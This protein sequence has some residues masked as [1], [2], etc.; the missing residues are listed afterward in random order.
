MNRK[1]KTGGKDK[2]VHMGATGTARPLCG[3]KSAKVSRRPAEI[4]CEACGRAALRA[5]KEHEAAVDQ[6]ADEASQRQ[7][8]GVRLLSQPRWWDKPQGGGSDG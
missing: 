6:A 1:K 4:D 7:R 8:E 5:V 2:R 3:A